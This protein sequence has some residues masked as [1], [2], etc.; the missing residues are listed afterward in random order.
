MPEYC[1]SYIGPPLPTC[2]EPVLP[3]IEPNET[4]GTAS[5]AKVLI[6]NPAVNGPTFYSKL[7][8]AGYEFAGPV[9]GSWFVAVRA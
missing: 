6:L 3:S 1:P 2:K 9:R 4:T 8:I 7:I 5:S